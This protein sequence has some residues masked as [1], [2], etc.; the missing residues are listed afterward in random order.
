MTR[1]LLVVGHGMVGH[2]LVE[3]VRALDT[4][5]TWR[6]V[7]V[8]EEHHPAYDRVGLSSYLDGKSKSDLTLVG[9]DFLSD[10]RMDLVLGS[11]VVSVDRTA[12]SVET[13]HG[14]RIWYDALVLATGSRPFVPPVPGHDL[15]GC[16]TYRTFDDLDALRAAASPGRPGVVVGGGLLGLE[17][18]NALRLLGMRTHVVETAPH[19]MPAQLD[20]GAAHVLHRRVAEL[21]LR[22]HCA[23]ATASIEAGTDGAVRAVTLSDGTVLDADV[24]VFAAGVRPRDELADAAGLERGERGGVVVDDLCRTA[25]ERVWAIGECACVQGRCHGLVAPGYRM[26][27]SVARQLTGRTPEP[28]DGAD[29]STALKLLGVR[30]ATF[31]ATRCD[32]GQALEAVFAEDTDRY[33]KI[34]LR[35]DSGDLLGGILAGDTGS[36]TAL[37]SLVGR[38]P[39]ADLERLLLP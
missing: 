20:A 14:E 4:E 11:P 15:P 2:R 39:P 25:D 7:V 28:F 5:R 36:W 38:R 35:Q 6:V 9:A 16:F 21:G 17:A 13:A 34:L 1:T 24:V 8:G 29:T 30:I 37:R 27:D 33:A 10:P 23:T 12:R 18:A 26:A 32:H 22:V 3:Q 19:L 31:G